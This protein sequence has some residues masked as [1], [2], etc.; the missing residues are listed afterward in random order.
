MALKWPCTSGSLQLDGPLPLQVQSQPLGPVLGQHLVQVLLLQPALASGAEQR[1]EPPGGGRVDMR[2]GGCLS[3]TRCLWRF[4]LFK[5]REGKMWC[6]TTQMSN[7]PITH[8]QRQGFNRKQP[9]HT[10]GR[11]S[12]IFPTLSPTDQ[13]FANLSTFTDPTGQRQLP[14]PPSRKVSLYS[15]MKTT[16]F[17]VDR[18][19]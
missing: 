7:S 14:V 9:G 15:L 19:S 17:K 18:R 8:K 10:P 12:G 16:H 6:N 13:P 1:V 11:M 2:R 4:K 3:P 5:H